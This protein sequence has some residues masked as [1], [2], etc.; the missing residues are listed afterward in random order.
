MSGVRVCLAT[1]NRHKVGEL[2]AL[3]RTY[4]PALLARIELVSLAELGVTD[5]AVEDGETFADNARKK[6]EFALARTGMWSLADDSGLEVEALAGAPGVHSA[7]YGGEPR[8]DARNIAKLLTAL[9]DVPAEHRAARFVCTLCL[10]G[11]GEPPV[12]RSGTCTG[13]LLTD[14]HGAGGFGYDP[15]FVPDEAQWPQGMDGAARAEIRGKTFGEL[16]GEQK[17]LI[18]HRTGAIRAMAEV[19]WAR[20]R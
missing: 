20:F 1:Q 15:L 2:G 6:A 4:E 9:R 14:V 18:S 8:S 7:Y 13:R 19:L 10:I 5:E 3:L 11:P 17:N 16:S 12:F